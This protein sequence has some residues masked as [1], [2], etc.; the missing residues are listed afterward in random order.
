[1][2]Q[3]NSSEAASSILWLPTMDLQPKQEKKCTM[4]T[5]ISALTT[6]ITEYA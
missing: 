4:N 2:S 5:K 1:M 3:V 6:T